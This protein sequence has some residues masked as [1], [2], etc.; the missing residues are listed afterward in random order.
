[1]KT[2][3]FLKSLILSI[4]AIAFLSCGG[5]DGGGSG[6]GSGTGS[7]TGSGS[8]SGVNPIT[9]ITITA[10]NSTIELGESVA[11]IVTDSNNANKTALSKIYV[12]GQE[13]N[14][15]VFTPT[16][17]GTYEVYAT[18]ETFTSATITVTVN[19]A[20]VNVVIV[21]SDNYTVLPGETFTF[22]AYA[23]GSTNVTDDAVYYVDGNEITGNQFT[24][25]ERGAF[26]I[27]AS[28]QGVT[29]N[30]IT[31][32]A[33][34]V[35]KVL[36]EDYTG[37][38]CGYC[39]RLAYNL[40]QAE[41]QSDDI[42]GVALHNGSS[43][44]MVAENYED[45]LSNAYGITGYPSG[46]INRTTVWNESVS[47]LLNATGANGTLGLGLDTSLNGTA[48]TIDVKVGY[49]AATSDM[50]LVVYLLEDGKIYPQTN[51]MNNDSSSPWY[52]AGNPINDF[53]HNNILR[54]AFTDIFGDAIPN[55]VAGGEYTQTFNVQ[56]PS[57]VEDDTKLQVIAFV[58]DNDGNAIN[59]MRVDLGDSQDYQ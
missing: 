11:F 51:Y 16:L 33:G 26:S 42:Y 23:N 21:G 50:K 32:A 43:D 7:G 39:P 44:P 56:M 45:L 58:V 13:L 54:K 31:V 55:G 35:Q 59:A 30:P 9:S 53:E 41:S 8:G 48:I 17:I 19:E 3:N 28:Y 5:S 57:N 18:F 14:S 20:T 47:Q 38:W 52:G 15:S 36:V 22:S 6:S 29:S 34:Y 46:R 12:D 4:T 49:I 10:N 40:E 2:L 37:T 27:T 25:N 24:S 1:M